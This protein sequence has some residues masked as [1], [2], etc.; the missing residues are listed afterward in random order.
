MPKM[1]AVKEFG[2]NNINVNTAMTFHPNLPLHFTRY[3]LNISLT[4]SNYG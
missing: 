4:W 1:F 3:N 2:L